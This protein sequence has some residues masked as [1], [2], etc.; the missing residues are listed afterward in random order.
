MKSLNQGFSM[1]ELMFVVAIIAILAA[2]VYPSYQEQIRKAGRTEAK[3]LMVE[4]SAK[5]ERFR[6]SNTGYAATL[7]ALGYPG[8]V[9]TE[10][11]KYTLTMT[12]GLTGTIPTSY[13]LTATPLTPQQQKDRCG[14]LSVSHTGAQTSSGLSP[15]PAND[16]L[17]W[18]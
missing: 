14:A 3:N 7:A 11:G 16:P 6:Y 1:I 9:Q 15:F 17:C 4:M 5:Q 2:I 10:N 12:V 18:K 13:V 8:T